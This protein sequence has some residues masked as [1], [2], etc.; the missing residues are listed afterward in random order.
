MKGIQ[1]IIKYHYLIYLSTLMNPNLFLLAQN[2]AIIEININSAKKWHMLYINLKGLHEKMKSESSGYYPIIVLMKFEDTRNGFIKPFT[3]TT[4]SQKS[5]HI[6]WL[7]F[8][9]IYSICIF[10]P[11]TQQSKVTVT[12]VLPSIDLFPF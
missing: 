9:S 8:S 1:R 4:F 11:S 7:T 12:N 3:I 10:N 2:I 6:S 5:T